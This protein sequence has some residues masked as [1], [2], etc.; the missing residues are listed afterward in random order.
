MKKLKQKKGIIISFIVG[1]IL[2]SCITVYATS[3]FAKDVMYKDGKSVEQAL[4]ELYTNKKKDLGEYR[5]VNRENNG[6]LATSGEVA[7][8]S[9][10]LTSK[11]FPTTNNGH[12]YVKC[13][14]SITNTLG[15]KFEFSSQIYFNNESSGNMG[16]I[17]IALL[18]NNE[19][20][21]EIDI[22]DSWAGQCA[23]TYYA[24]AGETSIY[25]AG[26]Y[27][28]TRYNLSGRYAIIGDGSKLYFYWG[29]KLMNSIEYNNEISYDKIEIWFSKYSSY[30]VPNWYIESL[31]IGEPLYYKDY[32]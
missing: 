27:N 1:V 15:D 25:S 31:Y 16:H 20:K 5:F 13:E 26:T 29:T 24:N 23:A 19:K 18:K 12:N 28:D 8:D 3:Y 11:N 22:G 21:L 30:S 10:G 32:V 14:K 6:F 17:G 7:F 2:A 9:I 4:N